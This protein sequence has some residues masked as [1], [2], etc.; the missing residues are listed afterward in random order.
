M[1]VL[2]TQSHKN[3]CQCAADNTNPVIND[4]QKNFSYKI[5]KNIYDLLVK[6]ALWKHQRMQ[7]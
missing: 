2:Q 4:L 7:L 5:K 1:K 3:I 6:V